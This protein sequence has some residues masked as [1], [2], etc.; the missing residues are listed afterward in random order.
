[1]R[2]SIGILAVVLTVFAAL[3]IWMS[4]NIVLL[5]AQE[6]IEVDSYLNSQTANVGKILLGEKVQVL[7]CDDLKS[8]SATHVSL[9]IRQEGY[10]IK[11]KF[12]LELFPF[13]SAVDR[14]ISFSCPPAWH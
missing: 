13:W 7:S 5:I 6:N 9:K 14:P 1:M 2:W 4:T 11:G 12:R 8:Y 3:S 10:V